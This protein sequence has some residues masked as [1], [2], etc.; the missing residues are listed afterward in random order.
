[1]RDILNAPISAREKLHRIQETELFSVNTDN[2][3]WFKSSEDLWVPLLRAHHG[4]WWEVFPEETIN[5]NG[6]FTR[7]VDITPGQKETN[8]LYLVSLDYFKKVNLAAHILY[9]HPRHVVELG[10]GFGQVARLLLKAKLHDDKK[11]SSYTIIDIPESLEFAKLFLKLE[12]TDEEFN[13][14]VFIDA[15]DLQSEEN[16]DWIDSIAG[17]CTFFNSSSL[18]EMDG[19]TQTFYMGWLNN[20][21]R[22]ARMVLLNRLFNTFDPIRE[23]FRAKEARWYW[24][25]GSNYSAHVWDFEPMFTVFNGPELFHNRELFLV[26]ERNNC[27]I[28]PDMDEIAKISNS[29]MFK[30]FKL[31]GASR[32]MN[33]LLV[34]TKILVLLCESVRLS[35][36]PPYIE[37]LLKYLHMIRKAYPFEEEAY[38]VNRYNNYGIYPPLTWRK[39]GGIYALWV[40]VAST[41]VSTLQA[42]KLWFRN[43]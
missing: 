1:M 26:M 17:N 35:I 38:L 29:F 10:A 42:V 25:I 20:T 13:K 23:A 41:V 14:V 9:S 37:L 33:S 27:N 16:K 28:V 4:R 19:D 15:F 11:L 34:D 24:E 5:Y 12:L 36:H 43:F 21:L 39:D 3:Q 18:G 8:K 7:L 31:S 32:H 2:K 30:N 40:K 6:K 22:P